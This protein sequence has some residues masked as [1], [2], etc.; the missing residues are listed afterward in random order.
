MSR[1]SNKRDLKTVTEEAKANSQSACR[2][3]GQCRKAQEGM[4]KVEKDREQM[5]E[6]GT[7]SSSPQPGGLY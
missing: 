1:I 2:C 7:H 4:S 3:G 6:N 5:I